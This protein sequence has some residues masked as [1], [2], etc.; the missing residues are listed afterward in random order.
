[1]CGIVG[2]VDAGGV[3]LPIYYALFALQHRG[4]ESAGISTYD[5]ILFYKYKGQGLVADVFDEDVLESLQGNIGVGHVR[6]PTTGANLPENVQPFNFRFKNHFFAIAHNGNLIN[7]R[8]LRQEFER[9]GEIFSTTT[10]TE[11]IASAIVDEFRRSENIV[12][13]IVHCMRVLEGSYSVVLGPL[14]V[15]GTM[16]SVTVRQKAAKIAM[17][18]SFLIIVSPPLLLEQCTNSLC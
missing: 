1:M 13:A 10:D 7:A 14:L 16:N 12:D 18:K 3:S 5:G 11:L 8:T 15:G 2:I 17:V 6:Y 4:Q 9:K